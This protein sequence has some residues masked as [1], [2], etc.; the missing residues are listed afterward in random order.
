MT[1]RGVVLPGVG[2]VFEPA[3][4]EIAALGCLLSRLVLHGCYGDG[5]GPRPLTHHRH[6]ESNPQRSLHVSALLLSAILNLFGFERF[7]DDSR[8]RN[9]PGNSEGSE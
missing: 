3:R 7:P 1:L 4:F 2:M 5:S 6:P 9:L 8:I